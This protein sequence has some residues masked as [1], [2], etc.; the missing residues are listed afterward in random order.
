[1]TIPNEIT[2]VEHV[3]DASTTVFTIPFRFLEDA[4]LLVSLDGVVQT[5]TADYTLIGAGETSG[6]SCTFITAPATAAVVRIEQNAPLVQNDNLN[7]DVL[8][9]ILD[10]VFVGL[11]TLKNSILT[12]ATRVTALEAAGGGGTGAVASVF[13]RVGSVVASTNDYSA[14][15]ISNNSAVAGTQVSGALNTL[16]TADTTIRGYLVPVGATME[17]P[18]ATEPAGWYFR[19]GRSLSRA[20]HPQLFAVV[21]TAFGSVDANSFNLPDDRGQFKRGL[22]DGRA[23]G[24]EDPDGAGRT[25]G[26]YQAGQL[27][28]H[29][30]T[31]AFQH[32]TA[33][34]AGAGPGS[35]GTNADSTGSTGGSE[36]RSANT[37]TRWIIFARPDLADA[38]AG[39]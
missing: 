13:G 39:A 11:H 5:L 9:T 21:G 14:S 29:T 36:T 38:I 8:E 30:H 19:D 34:S 20:T 7:N 33:S 26:D 10:R 12:V 1:M 4:D 32:V 35:Q 2:F 27:E 17:W 18:G 6:W 37:G 3:G 28:A 24:R 25:L 23:D 15:Q 16:N 31:G 22:N